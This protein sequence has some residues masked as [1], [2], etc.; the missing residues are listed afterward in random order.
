MALI[1]S[2]LSPLNLRV[3]LQH[4]KICAIWLILKNY[5]FKGVKQLVASQNVFMS[6]FQNISWKANYCGGCRWC[7]TGS[8]LPRLCT[9]PS[10]QEGWCYGLR[11]ATFSRGSLHPWEPPQEAVLSLWG[12][13]SANNRLMDP[14]TWLFCLG[15][16]ELEMRWKP[17]FSWTHLCRH[18][19]P[20]LA[21][22]SHSL[23]GLNGQ[24]SFMVST[25]STSTKPDPRQ[26]WSYTAKA[27]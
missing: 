6:T 18:F 23:S 3:G 21:S 9:R 20:A 27:V 17:G 16:R 11:A 8:S 12:Q 19:P 1:V 4:L 15:S 10:C 22:L 14:D 25:S 5:I 26:L 2:Q 7:P 13:A 24:H